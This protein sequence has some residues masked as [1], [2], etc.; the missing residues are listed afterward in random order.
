MERHLGKLALDQLGGAVDRSV[1]DHDHLGGAG[2]VP[3]GRQGAPELVAAV[4]CRDQDGDL[5]HPAVNASLYMPT[6]CSAT[7]RH[8]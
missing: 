8:R 4:A 5:A 2:L 3:H 1:V 7:A 6:I